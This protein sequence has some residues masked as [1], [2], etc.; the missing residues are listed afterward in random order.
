MKNWHIIQLKRNSHRL[1]ERNLNQQGFTTFLPLQHFTSKSRSKFSTNIK[2]LFPGY[3]FVRVDLYGKPWQ[4]VN[5]TLG[6]SRLIC[7]DGIPTRV[8]EEIIAALMSR[9]DSSGKLLPPKSLTNGDSV[10]VISGALANFVASV[11][12][13]D[14]EHRIWVLMEIMGQTTRV[15]VASDQIRLQN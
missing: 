15:Q 8:P 3:M 7:Q 11:E 12:T 14:S 4:K 13:F 2:P 6:V 1:A 9:C 10:K 5:S